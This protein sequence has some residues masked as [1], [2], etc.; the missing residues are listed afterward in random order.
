ILMEKIKKAHW[1]IGLF[2]SGKKSYGQILEITNKLNCPAPQI[3]KNSKGQI[4]YFAH[5]DNPE[6][7]QYKPSEIIAHGGA[8]IRK[9]LT[10]TG[11]D[12]IKIL[13]EMQDWIDETGCTEFHELARYARNERFDDWYDVIAT[14]ST[15]FLNAYIRS[16]RHGGDHNE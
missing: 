4:R 7:Y 3:M 12:K 8:D 14:Q 15:V 1:H 13:A 10:A 5:M 6:K 2:F 16:K 9:Y 11:G